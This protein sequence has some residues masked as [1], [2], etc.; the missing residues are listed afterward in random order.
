MESEKDFSTWMLVKGQI[1]N[2]CKSPF[3]HEREVWW[4]SVG[5]NVG[6]ETDGKGSTYARPIL[7]IKDFNHAT[8]WCLPV[9][10]RIKKSL[11]HINIDINDGVPQQVVLSQ[12]R[13]L[14]AKRLEERIGTIDEKAFCEIKAAITRFLM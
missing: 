8:F 11:Y 4:C 7:I 3:Y 2:K 12:L 13:V 5:L 9:T 6:F 1:H 14:D 10:T